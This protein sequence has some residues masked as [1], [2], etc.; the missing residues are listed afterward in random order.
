MTKFWNYFKIVWRFWKLV[1]MA[2]MTVRGP[3]HDKIRHL[4]ETHQ[5]QGAVKNTFHNLSRHQFRRCRFFSD[6]WISCSTFLFKLFNW[7]CT[8]YIL[9]VIG[10]PKMSIDTSAFIGQVTVKTPSALSN[11]HHQPESHHSSRNNSND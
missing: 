11:H 6:C 10:P 2:G 4:S 1:H 3:P 8:V 7:L 5:P 9:A